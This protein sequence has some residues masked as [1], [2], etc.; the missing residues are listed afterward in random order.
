MTA[1]FIDNPRVFI[2][3]I[4]LLSVFSLSVYRF[5]QDD[6]SLDNIHFDLPVVEHLA[7]QSSKDGYTYDI[8]SILNQNFSYLGK[9]H[10]SYAFL[11]E[12]GQ[13]VVKF[14]KFTYLK[15]SLFIDLL[16][17]LPF[18]ENYKKY[19]QKGKQKR[20]NR[21]FKGYR[22]AYEYDPANTG[23]LYI[24]LQKTNNLRKT[25]LVTDKYGVAYHVD[26][27]PVVFVI[28]R[29]A[30]M[31]REVLK[32]LIKENDLPLFQTRIRQIFQ[33]Y[34]DEYKKGVY[35]SDHNVMSNTG[36]L[37]NQAIRIDVG[38]LTYNEDFKDPKIYIKDL[39]KVAKKRLDGW[40]KK[41]YPSQYQEF[42]PVIEHELSRAVG[43]KVELN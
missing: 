37:E 5:F 23:M 32:G 26:L 24:H 13:Y 31:T 40:I 43:E 18:V 10:Q 20:L 41:N 30:L 3:V 12:D 25:L 36:F 1:K 21:I 4:L 16:P 2:A 15:P 7:A 22:L 35:D 29:K 42:G 17:T 14:F 28:Q 9:G 33:M 38:R 39:K 34:V 11:S 8:Q 6:F 19:V 27:D